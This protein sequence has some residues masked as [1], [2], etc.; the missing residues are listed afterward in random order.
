[1]APNAGFGPKGPVGFTGPAGPV[2]LDGV[3]GA[4]YMDLSLPC[5][6]GAGEASVRGSSFRMKGEC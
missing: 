5:A 2:G 4:G 1:M 6:Q 3:G